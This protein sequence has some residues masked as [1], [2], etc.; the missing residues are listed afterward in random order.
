V[1]RLRKWLK[2]NRRAVLIGGIA[3]IMP[4]FLLLYGLGSWPTAISQREFT[5]AQASSS[6]GI[7]AHNPLFL[8]TT[9][10]HWLINFGHWHVI[11]FLRLPS[12]MICLLA[13]GMMAYILR[14]WY[15]SRTALFGFALFISSSWF[16][17]IGRLATFDSLELLAIPLLLTS[18]LLLHSRPASKLVW[19]S[20]LGTQILLLYVPGMIWLV[21]ASMIL[22]R[23]EIS[24]ALRQCKQPKLRRLVSTALAVVLLSP[25]MYALTAHFQTRLITGL[26]GLP[27]RWP[28]ID[29]LLQRATQAVLFI[30]ARGTAPNDTW[31][32]HQPLFNALLVALFLIGVYF[33]AKHWQAPRTRLLATYLVVGSL[34]YIAGGLVGFSLLVPLLYLIV[35]AGGAYYLHLW[36]AVFPRNPLARLVGI[37]LLSLAIIISCVFGVR[38]YFIAWRY[39]PPAKAA[40]TI[41]HIPRSHL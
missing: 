16:L 35:A 17:H 2:K 6:P 4:V 9:F 19:Y 7:F 11:F 23:H 41:T 33:Y 30:G 18:Y 38:Q 13:A 31:L 27:D 22:Q 37:G 12:V 5:A 25:Y 40:F 39:H 14:R 24:T 26:L 1:K 10:L 3:V 21:T 32:N 29:S 20:W 36:L 28:G 15:G 34:L 8:P